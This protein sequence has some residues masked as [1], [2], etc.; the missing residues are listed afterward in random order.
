VPVLLLRDGGRLKVALRA[1][2]RGD[3]LLLGPD[4]RRL[5]VVRHLLLAHLRCDHARLEGR[6]VPHGAHDRIEP[7]RDAEGDDVHV[8]V[9]AV[10]GDLVLE[11]ELV[12]VEDRERLAGQQG[13]HDAAHV[14]T[15]HLGARADERTLDAAAGDDHVPHLQ[16]LSQLLLRQG[17]RESL[18]HGRVGACTGSSI[19]S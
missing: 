6:V 19:P 18:Q 14:G 13:R 1:D 9:R 8:A 5:L 7:L 17:R 12:L 15:T 2:G 3:L 10:D 4:E 11:R 16:P